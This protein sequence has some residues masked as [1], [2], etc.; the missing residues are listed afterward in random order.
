V[1]TRQPLDVSAELTNLRDFYDAAA[2]DAGL[3]LQLNAEG[4]NGGLRVALD[5]ALFQRAVGNV[6]ENAL[7]HTPS[8]GTVTI[9]ANAENGFLRVGVRDSGPGIPPEHL[10]HIFERFHRVDPARSRNTG[11]M[12][13]GLAIAR[14]I[15]VLH[16][17]SAD[18]ASHP[19]DGTQ[20]TLTFPRDEAAIAPGAE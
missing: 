2:A 18:A 4:A 5:R 17:G 19:G 13:L 9:S 14:S 7:A 6:V 12:G 1:V 8:G 20:V 10:P 16:G 15:A 3:T 11:G